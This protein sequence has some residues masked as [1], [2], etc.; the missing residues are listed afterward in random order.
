MI[1]KTAFWPDSVQKMVQRSFERCFLEKQYV[2]QKIMKTHCIQVLFKKCIL[3]LFILSKN[4]TP[5][6]NVWINKML[7][8]EMYRNELIYYIKKGLSLSSSLFLN[9]IS[10]HSEP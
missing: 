3:M 5:A 2:K 4:D 7:S 8:Y 1:F 9:G 10:S 6:M